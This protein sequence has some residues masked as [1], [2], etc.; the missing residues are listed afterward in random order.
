MSVLTINAGS[1]SIR[2]AF[3][4]SGSQPEKLEHGKIERI[5]QSGAALEVQA[6][7]GKRS[8]PLAAGSFKEAVD[9][10]LEWLEAQPQFAKLS[11]V[12]HRV[13]HGMAHSK[14]ARVTPR[15]LEELKAAIPYDPEHL[16][17]EIELIESL[18]RRFPRLDQVA[19]FD[20]A[21]HR[22][23]PRIATIL[24]VP[25]RYES[26]GVRRYGFHGLSY[27]FLLQEL[28]RLGDRA[29]EHGRVIL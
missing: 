29:C 15:L 17:Q 20:T 8:V 14:P 1:S 16:P 18:G 4:G 26:K 25:R 28:A 23:M 3:Y 13:V 12:G 21:F 22:N 27:T 11:A 5:G 2:F 19:C 7:A 24:P 9:S 10:L 6:A